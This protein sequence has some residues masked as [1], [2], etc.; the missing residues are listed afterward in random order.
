VKLFERLDR[1]C[2]LAH[3]ARSTRL[4]YCRWVDQFLRFHRAP[5]GRWR[6]PAELRGADVAA[7]LTHMAAD[8]RLSASSQNQAICAIVFLYETVLVDELGSDHLGD[9][10]ALRSVRPRTLPTVLS[11]GEVRRLIA[12][13][14]PET[15]TGVIIRLLYGT[16]MRIGE[17][18]TLRVR[19][20]DFERGQIVIRQGKGR[21][22]R[23]VM[24][25]EALRGLLTDH[26][27][28]RRELHERDLQRNAG[29]VPLPDAIA[30][31]A[32]AN[33]RE[34]GWQY[35]FAS[36]TARY[37]E[38]PDGTQRGVRW[39]T[40]PAHVSRT[41]VAAARAARIAKRVT[42]H[43]L[44]HSFATHLLEQGWDVRQLQTLLGH[45]SLETTMIYT[46]VMTKPAVAITS[47]L[48]RL[49]DPV[50]A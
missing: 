1:A 36:V 28:L 26:L 7:F 32:P 43:A 24:L 17:A 49:A 33:E 40:T 13:M 47:P 5:S 46:H 20:V 11:T 38:A 50:S 23:W 34:W 10:R 39:H 35:V 41:M 42:P 27:R 14:P 29:Y 18:C 30:N 19:D 16:G 31:K 12:A 22:D 25:P 6:T 48:D 4:Q 9:I 45:A 37:A 44:R 3:L 15:E 8:R 21:K 2:R